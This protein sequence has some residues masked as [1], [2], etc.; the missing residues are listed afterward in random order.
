M[1]REMMN[2]EQFME[3]NAESAEGKCMDTEDQQR[4]RLTDSMTAGHGS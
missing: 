1:V 4:K 3:W 2:K